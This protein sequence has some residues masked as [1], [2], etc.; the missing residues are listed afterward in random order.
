M[1]KNLGQQTTIPFAVHA[2]R[3]LIM[4][5]QK[6]GKARNYIQKISP[7][8]YNLQSGVVHS[9][10]FPKGKLQGSQV[11]DIPGLPHSVKLIEDS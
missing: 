2:C 11:G 8:R 7:V 6:T 5:V 1:A 9:P 4:I 10:I 3:G